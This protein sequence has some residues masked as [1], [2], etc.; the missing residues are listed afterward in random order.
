MKEIFFPTSLLKLCE[1]SILPRELL[2]CA[3]NSFSHLFS[4]SRTFHTFLNLNLQT[5]QTPNQEKN[6]KQAFLQ[7]HLTVLF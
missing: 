7:G 2:H 6:L 4:L 3:H 1:K 5:Q